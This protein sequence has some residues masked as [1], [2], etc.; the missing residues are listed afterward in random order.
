MLWSVDNRKPTLF[1]Y[2]RMSRQYGLTVVSF[3]SVSIL[4]WY[5]HIELSSYEL[6]AQEGSFDE[7][8]GFS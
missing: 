4:Y 2:T 7:W 6:S 5:I 3:F 1:S 8:S